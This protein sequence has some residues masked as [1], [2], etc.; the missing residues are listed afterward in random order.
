MGHLN[1]VYHVGYPYSFRQEGNPPTIQFSLAEDGLKADIDVDY[2]S[3][4]A[5]QAL[6]NGHLTSSNSDVRSGINYDLHNGRWQGFV[7]WWRGIFGDLGDDDQ[8]QNDLISLGPPIVPT[9][10]PPDRPRGAPIENV[11]DA[12]QEFLTDWLIRK[13]F[14]EALA[15]L[16]DQSLACMN[17]DDDAHQETIP[18]AEARLQLRE[19]MAGVA[20][21][22]GDTD[23]LT[24]AIEVVEP[25]DNRDQ[26]ITHPF[27]REFSVFGMETADA[28]E[29]LCSV[30][31]TTAPTTALSPV[32]QARYGI[33][34]GSLFRFKFGDREGGVL[35]LLWKLIE[36]QWQIV[37]YKV[38]TP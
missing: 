12:T 10:L 34:F 4:K 37:T 31:E 1:T 2:R 36:G 14:D 9:D 27:R 3:S 19:I 38:F 20:D 13:N 8:G 5:P 22:M 7:A 25:W 16:S 24:E 32:P 35:G 28:E 18:T 29:H 21:E 15:F 11:S 30:P 26:L 6:W 33:Y 17:L 23:N